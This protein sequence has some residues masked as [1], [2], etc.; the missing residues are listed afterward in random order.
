MAGVVDVDGVYWTLA[1][2]FLLYFIMF[3]LFNTKQ[4][5]RIGFYFF[6]LASNNNR[7]RISLRRMTSFE[8]I[9]Q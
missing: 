4:I 6:F 9:G 8:F 5:N 3:L 2:N 1:V 7:M